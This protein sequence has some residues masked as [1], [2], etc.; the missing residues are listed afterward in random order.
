MQ[1]CKFSQRYQV[2]HT[3]SRD[4]L[5][6]ECQANEHLT[7]GLLPAYPT[8][9][10]K[11]HLV[12]WNHCYLLPHTEYIPINGRCRACTTTVPFKK[13]SNSTSIQLPQLKLRQMKMVSICSVYLSFSV[14]LEHLKHWHCFPLFLFIYSCTGTNQTYFYYEGVKNISSYIIRLRN[15]KHQHPNKITQ[16]FVVHIF[17]WAGVIKERKKCLGNISF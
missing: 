8:P 3:A 13:A 4:M 15:K 9:S 6:V 10:S 14:L 5:G 1:Q 16:R 2:A 11:R 7:S 17:F 12:R